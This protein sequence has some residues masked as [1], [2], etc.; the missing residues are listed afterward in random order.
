MLDILVPGGFMGDKSR[1][2]NDSTRMYRLVRIYGSTVAFKD[3]MRI[4]RDII[5][6]KLVSVLQKRRVRVLLGPDPK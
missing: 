6:C 5:S 4:K 3:N 2:V 1:E